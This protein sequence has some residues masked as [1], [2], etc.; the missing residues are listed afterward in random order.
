MIKLIVENNDQ[1]NEWIRLLHDRFKTSFNIIFET[2][3]K[4]K[5]ILRDVVNYRKFREYAQC[6]IRLIKNV[7]L[8]N[9]QNQLNIIYNHIDSFLQ[10]NDIKR[11]KINQNVTLNELIKNLDE[12]KHDWWNYENKTLRNSQ[13][14]RLSFNINFQNNRSIERRDDRDTSSFN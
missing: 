1:L 7:G 8:N 13:F 12:F 5:Y 9:L 2:F 11:F 6:I 3:I 14:N 10:K 4:K